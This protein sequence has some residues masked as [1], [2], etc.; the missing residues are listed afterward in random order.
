MEFFF[1]NA[2]G[3]TLFNRM[4]AESAHW[5]VQELALD[6]VFPHDENKVIERGMRVAFRDPVTDKF[7]MF[8]IRQCVE[9]E[10][11]HGQR[12]TAEHIAVAELSDDHIDKKKITSKTAAQALTTVLSGTLWS[13]GTNTA[14]GTQNADI[15]RGDVWQAVN[16]IK[17]NWN[18]YITPRIVMS[19]QGQIMNRYLD[20]TP[21]G[22]TFNGLRLSIRK[23]LLD[24]S[25]TY[26]DEDV[27]TALYGYGGTVDDA[28]V[29]FKDVVW[30]ATSSHPAKPANQTYLE[31]PAATA[32]YGRDGRARF[33][34]YQNA[35]ITDPAVLL[36]K[37]WEAL[38]RTN[39][40]KISIRGTC[41]DLYRLGYKDTPLQLHDL[42][43]V[44]IE[45]TGEVYQKEIIM[46]DYDLLDP[47]NNNVDIGDY[48]PNIVYINRETA[49]K[50]RG[51][52]GGGSRG[53]TPNEVEQ[54]D[55]FAEF[56]KTNNMIGMVVG[57]TNGGYYIKAG[58]ISLAI[59]E[60][61][62]AGSY[63]TSAYIKADHINISATSTVHTLAGDIEHASNGRLVI[64]NAG[65]LYVE[66][67]SGGTT[68][69]FGIW[70]RGNLTGGVMV[71]QINGQTTLKLQADVID[72]NGIVTALTA[73]EITVSA[74]NCTNN[75]IVSGRLSG[76]VW[77]SSLK[78]AAV[79]ATWKSKTVVTSVTLPTITLQEPHA[80]V[81]TGGTTRTIQGVASKT[82]GSVSTE[83]LYYLGY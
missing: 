39:K 78:V 61:G 33:G 58:E 20:I 82:N 26:N 81:D 11:D 24:P 6:V 43:I 48:I 69:Q 50:A 45:E 23:N 4:D 64:K 35:E 73:R 2:A 29:T 59:N 66:R 10:P 37:T 55:T 77:A 72:I 40:P 16:A 31:D 25:V 65:G 7:Q 56:V 60:S 28:E 9:T 1:V 36:Q 38:Q 46:L 68:A 3:Q 15:P 41:V 21:A 30:S 13:L 51:G 12:I 34:Y 19:A 52:G 32:L 80:F 14:S 17:S 57:T 62:T 47:S 42:A 18:V 75:V 74:L 53:Q 70:D 79:D 22:G 83:T 67:T 44:E 63:E 49:N 76:T 27:L 54:S 8:E 5:V 71:T